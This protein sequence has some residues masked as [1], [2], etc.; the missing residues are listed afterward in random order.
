MIIR[1]EEPED[2]AA[3]RHVEEQAFGQPAEADLVDRLR[4]A[5]PEQISLVAIMEDELVGHILFTPAVIEYEDGSKLNGFGLAPVAVL[6]AFQ[7]QGVG[8]ALIQSGL[9]ELQHRNQP[10]VIVL[11]HPEYYPRFGFQPAYRYHL[12]C[13][14]TGENRDT[15]LIHLLKNKGFQA[16]AGD[17]RYHPVFDS[18]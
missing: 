11:G 4:A 18:L 6:P 13:K 1:P 12:T 2:A 5:C 15:F 14:F 9:A 16:K 17:A 8:T 3:I 10:F 7:K